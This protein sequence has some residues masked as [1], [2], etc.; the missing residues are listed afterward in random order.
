MEGYPEFPFL[1]AA[2][3]FAFAI[4]VGIV[5][6]VYI[7]RELR[8]GSSTSAPALQSPRA[9]TLPS[10]ASPNVSASIVDNS[11]DMPKDNARVYPRYLLT[12]SER[13]FFDFLNQTLEGK[14]IITTKIPLKNILNK[15]GWLERGLF[16][17]Y[18]YGHADY[19]V[20]DPL[21][22]K[23]LLAIELDDSSHAI[24]RRQD[25]DRRKDQLLLRSNIKLL[26]FP[27]GIVWGDTERKVILDSLPTRKSNPQTSH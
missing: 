4:I 10:E 23:T 5:A 14:Y 18:A 27:T 19:V 13:S 8:R 11:A 22:K 6:L 20:L 9:V 1:I 21:T 26:R 17:M 7:P 2:T 12:K 3:L 16:T 15:G 24:P 25:A